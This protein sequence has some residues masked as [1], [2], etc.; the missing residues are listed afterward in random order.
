MVNSYNLLSTKEE[1]RFYVGD[2]VH[3]K[4]NVAH[5]ALPEYYPDCTVIGK[6]VTVYTNML[7]VYWGE[8]SGTLG[9]H[10]CLVDK[11]LVTKM[12]E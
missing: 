5:Y 1:I 4:G 11:D 10:T 6:V 3:M 9:N 12:E 8:D 2:K 7:L